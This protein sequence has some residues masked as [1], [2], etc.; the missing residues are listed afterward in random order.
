MANTV[1]YTNVERSEKAMG[2]SSHYKEPGRLTKAVMNPLVQL[3]TRLGISVWGSRI[4]EVRGR[5][6]GEPRRTPVN[7][8]EVDGRN[9][10]V[11][12]RGEGQWVRNVRADDGRLALLLGRHRDER[13][14][15]ELPDSEKSPI[16]R[17]YLRKWKMEVGV[18]FD[19]VSADSEEED[20]QRIA[21]DHPVFVLS[22][23]VK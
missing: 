19:G 8:L 11:S 14:A 3:F 18:F 22:D 4:L 1:S 7:L 12:P 9:Y 5:K 15:R 13:V 2:D 23:A 21:P 17:A 20:V 10:L 16:L 6:S